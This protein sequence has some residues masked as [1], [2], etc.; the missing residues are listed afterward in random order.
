M[1]HII[2]W[3]YHW[4][5]DDERTLKTIGYFRSMDK[6]RGAIEAV[7]SKSGFIDYPNGFGVD[8]VAIDQICWE[9]GFIS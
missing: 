7:K 6:A 2:Y 5:N 1:K 9:D 4:Y 8:E 3:V